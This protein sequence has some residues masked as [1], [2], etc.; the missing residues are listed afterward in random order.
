MVGGVPPQSIRENS[1]KKEMHQMPQK[2]LMHFL[3]I[4]NCINAANPFQ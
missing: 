1:L 4:S 2:V 3:L